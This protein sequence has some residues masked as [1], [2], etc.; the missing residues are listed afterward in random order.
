LRLALR[1]AGQ[2]PHLHSRAPGQVL[3]FGEWRSDR[4][5]LTWTLREGDFRS[6]MTIAPTPDCIFYDPFSTVTDVSMWTLDC[7]ERVFAACTGH[8][9]ELFTYSASTMARAALL[10]AGFVVARGA[11]TGRKPETTLAMTPTA[12]V[13]AVARG[14]VVLGPEWLDRWRRSHTRFPS[15]VPTTGHLALGERIAGL[16]QFRVA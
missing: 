8:D 2:F 11:P 14:R 10:G 12:A 13:H 15:D 9:T 16:P 4:V 1:H 5:P 6:Q 7:F 3:R